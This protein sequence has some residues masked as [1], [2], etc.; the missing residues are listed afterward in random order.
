MWCSLGSFIFCALGRLVALGYCFWRLG[1]RRVGAHSF[2]TGQQVSARSELRRF[3][4]RRRMRFLFGERSSHKRGRQNSGL[5]SGG[6]PV[7]RLC[8]LRLRAH[9]RLRRCLPFASQADS[10]AP[11]TLW[12]ARCPPGKGGG[13]YCKKN[14]TEDKRRSPP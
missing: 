3:L 12:N 7:H 2:F 8:V 13:H 9:Q 14:T 1:P 4:W 6:G 10:F 5:K 11:S